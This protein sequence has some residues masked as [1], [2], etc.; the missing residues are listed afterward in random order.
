M[1]GRRE[2]PDLTPVE[3]PSGWHRP[4]S[5]Q[6]EIARLIR[7]ELQKAGVDD[8]EDW[9]EADDFDVDD[10]ELPYSPHEMSD[11][12]GDAPRG[13][14]KDLLTDAEKARKKIDTG[15][16]SGAKVGDENGGASSVDEARVVDDPSSASG[17]Q[18]RSG[19][20]EQSS[21][22]AGSKGSGGRG[23]QRDKESA[24]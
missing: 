1:S 13:A 12:E 2:E 23:T 17:V 10:E 16:S 22:A 4:M 14:L 24:E 20:A 21:G 7:S 11:L 6:E 9:E 5:L 19:K 8:M 3:M 18:R 15:D